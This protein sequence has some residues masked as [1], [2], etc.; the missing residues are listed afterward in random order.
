VCL[1]AVR[2][3]PKVTGLG[4]VARL[5]VQ[6]LEVGHVWQSLIV[7]VVD[8]LLGLKKERNYKNHEP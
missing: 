3:S 8:G 2:C 5:A 7:Q 1:E 4:L 6:V